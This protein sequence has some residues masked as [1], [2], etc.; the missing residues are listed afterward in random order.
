[1][2]SAVVA[3]DVGGTAMKGALVDRQGALLHVEIRPTGRERG[4]DAV[5][6]GIVDFTAA[7]TEEA[8]DGIAAAGVVVPGLVNQETGTAVYAANL[9]WHDVP[10]GDLVGK[11]LD[12]P[13]AVAH[14]VRTGGIAEG[15]VGAARECGDFLFL[16]IGTGIAA[17]IVLNGE[18]Y[19]GANGF[20]GEMGHTPVVPHGEPC[21]CGQRGCLETYASAASIPRRYMA[22]GGAPVSGA[23]E[24]LARAEAG[25]QL[26]K[27]AWDQAIDALATAL[28]SYSHLMDPELVVIGGGLA[29]AGDK[30]LEPLRT[31]LASRLTFRPPPP[32]VP[33]ALGSQAGCLGA[34]II[35]WRAAGET[36]AGEDWTPYE[37]DAA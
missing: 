34:A 15:L 28:A 29:E 4:P 9:G 8:P 32:L 6:A 1:M 35:A 27:D 19:G 33:A 23:E 16:P 30:L 24:V 17:A 13:V 11:R 7:L 21:A 2:S 25:D 12:R 31:E 36:T 20:G 14:D 22:A 10:L 37:G 26:A 3:L 5:V 18:P